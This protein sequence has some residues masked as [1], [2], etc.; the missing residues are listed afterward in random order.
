MQEELLEYSRSFMSDPK[1][2]KG[3]TF[4][5][6][7]HK[8]QTSFIKFI[9]NVT[10]VGHC[11]VLRQTILLL[12]RM[13][14]FLC[15]YP[16]CLSDWWI[17]IV[18]SPMNGCQNSCL[19]CPASNAGVIIHKLKYWK[20][21]YKKSWTFPPRDKQSSWPVIDKRTSEVPQLQSDRLPYAKI[22]MTPIKSAPLN[23]RSL[24]QGFVYKQTALNMRFLS[25]FT[26]QRQV[27]S[28]DKVSTNQRPEMLQFIYELW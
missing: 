22:S 4:R 19:W 12:A 20:T 16:F 6:K 5:A 11:C 9:L 26:N 7:F 27:R 17:F 21:P 3:K 14:T 25:Y 15:N 13:K 1:K 8:T 28:W 18:S 2:N 24:V 23:I 10:A